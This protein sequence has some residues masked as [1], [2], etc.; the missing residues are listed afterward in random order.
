R[1]VEARQAPGRGAAD[2]P[3]PVAG[4]VQFLFDGKARS[5]SGLAE[6]PDG[7]AK[8]TPGG[9]SL[10]GQPLVGR[11]R[12]GDDGNGGTVDRFTGGFMVGSDYSF[13][14]ELKAGVALGFLCTRVK[15]DGGLGKGTVHSYQA[16][17]YAS[18]TPGAAFVDAALGYGRSRYETSRSVTFGN[19]AGVASGEADGN[20]LSAELSAGTRVALAGESWIEPRVGLRWDR[21]VRGGFT[22]SGTPLL[23]L[24]EETATWNAL[25]SSLGLRVGTRLAVGETV[26]EPTGLLGWEHDWRDVDAS[27][28]GALNGAR[29]TVRSSR[30]S[31]DAAVVGAGV[32]VTMTQQVSLQVGYLGEIRRRESNHGLSAGLRWSW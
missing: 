23:S 2:A 5:V 20:D 24:T 14:P 31:R 30:P 12:S 6:G 17:A 18:W 3:G 27:A 29:F 26:V 28:T 1:A 11:G 9:A 10:W 19:V 13:D 7:T 25:R 4:V 22:E 32:N 8:A 21:L 15:A 16:T